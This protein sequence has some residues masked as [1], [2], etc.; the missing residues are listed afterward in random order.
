MLVKN[1]IAMAISIL[2][3][4]TSIHAEM[5][6]FAHNGQLETVAS[7]GEGKKVG[8]GTT[9]KITSMGDRD[10][11][12]SWNIEFSGVMELDKTE[13]LEF[14]VSSDDGSALFIDGKEVVMN[15]GAHGTVQDALPGARVET[16]GEPC[17]CAH[18]ANRTDGAWSVKL[19][20]SPGRG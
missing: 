4:A 18:G 14:S 10:F 3:L 11:G 17:V 9:N 1:A 13:R 20:D 5:T 6:Y 8:E 15:D 2:M 7:M 16:G 12:G 19:P